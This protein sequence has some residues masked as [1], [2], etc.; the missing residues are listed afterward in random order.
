MGRLSS[1]TVLGGMTFGLFGVP[2]T[3]FFGAAWL[4]GGAAIKRWAQTMECQLDALFSVETQ[5]K[6]DCTGYATE[7]EWAT[8]THASASGK[9]T[10]SM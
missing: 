6:P 5:T 4:F 1:A 9:T 8:M 7:H 3:F 2:S 10:Q